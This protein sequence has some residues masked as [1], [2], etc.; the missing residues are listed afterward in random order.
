MDPLVK[1][2]WITLPILAVGGIV[3]LRAPSSASTWFDDLQSASLGLPLGPHWLR[4][5]LLD[6]FGSCGVCYKYRKALLQWSN[7]KRIPWLETLAACLFS[8]FG[9]TTLVGVLLGQP[10]AWTVS[11]NAVRSLF[12]VWWLTFCCPFDAWHKLIDAS[13]ALRL[14][15]DCGAWLSSAHAITSWGSEKAIAAEHHVAR[16]AV[17]STVLAGTFGASGGTLFAATLNQRGTFRGDF[18]SLRKAL[19]GATL[20]YI[21]RDPHDVLGI[22]WRPATAKLVIAFYS[23]LA[24]LLPLLGLSYLSPQHFAERVFCFVLH[25]P[26]FHT[27]PPTATRGMARSA[28]DKASNEATADAPTR[29]KVA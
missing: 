28:H 4:F 18:A 17:F 10:P 9:G 3:A 13:F 20:Y 26:Q 14:A 22:G 21:L 1:W 5:S 29:P 16:S 27:I 12:L 19:V 23:I 24:S 8:Q 6:L 11:H 2:R 15:L 25:I 7:A